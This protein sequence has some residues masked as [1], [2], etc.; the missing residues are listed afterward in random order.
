MAGGAG[1]WGPAGK[2]PAWEGAPSGDMGSGRGMEGKY[3]V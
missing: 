2:D 1:G 3:K